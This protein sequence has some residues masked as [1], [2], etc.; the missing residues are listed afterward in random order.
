MHRK[1]EKNN[2]IFQANFL[3]QVWWLRNPL[4]DFE[5]TCIVF[6]VSVGLTAWRCMWVRCLAGSNPLGSQSSGHS[7]PALYSGSWSEKALQ[8]TNQ[9]ISQSISVGLSTNQSANQLCR[10]S[11]L[12]HHCGKNTSLSSFLILGK[13]F[14]VTCQYLD[15]R[16]FRLVSI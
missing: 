5:R 15:N 3:V 7:P 14:L 10:I 1:V 12:R 13:L 16:V 8:I 11:T 4:R 2:N 9:P 6:K